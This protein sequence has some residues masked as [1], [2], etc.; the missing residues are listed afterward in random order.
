MYILIDI[1]W[2]NMVRDLS[3]EIFQEC[4]T[5]LAKQVGE[6]STVTQSISSGLSLEQGTE[7]NNEFMKSKYSEIYTLLDGRKNT[8]IEHQITLGKKREYVKNDDT[9]GSAR[10]ESI[11]S[12]VENSA[13]RLDTLKTSIVSSVASIHGGNINVE[14]IID[15]LPAERANQI[16]RGD[17]FISSDYKYL[18][19]NGYAY[20][21]INSYAQHNDATGP[22]ISAVHEWTTVNEKTYDKT[23][24]DWWGAVTGLNDMSSDDYA[25]VINSELSDKQSK[26]LNTFDAV[27][28]VVKFIESARS[29]IAITVTFQENEVGDRRVFIAA[30]NST[31]RNIYEQWAG[32]SY[33]KL[34]SCQ[35]KAAEKEWSDE[36]ANYYMEMSGNEIDIYQYEY[37]IV[38]TIDERHRDDKYTSMISFDSEG[39]MYE[40][41]PVYDG[42]SV[43]IQRRGSFIGL[44]RKDIYEFELNDTMQIPEGYRDVFLEG[45]NSGFN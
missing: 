2:G 11:L 22:V 33:S 13:D 24:W 3:L 42:D 39:N 23:T 40:T 29:D 4:R 38:T 26:T 43:V 19:Y 31:Y 45:L 6:L 8:I 12:D 44:N 36:I 18:Y 5:Q 17:V 35:D 27:F 28:S 37:D 7:F 20:E 25:A 34:D 30:N 9:N 41:I 21:I 15:V 1:L 10:L 16:K 32:V 14:N